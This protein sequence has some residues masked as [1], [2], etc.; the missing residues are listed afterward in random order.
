M[1]TSDADVAPGPA[2]FAASVE[3][4]ADR[5]GVEIVEWPANEQRR[6]HL[7]RAGV[8][9]LLLVDGDAAVPTAI[10]IDEDWVRVPAPLGDIEVRLERLVRSLERLHRERPYV[11]SAHILHYGG[12]SIV[13]SPAQAIVVAALLEQPGRIVS[14][15]GLEREIWPNGTPGPKALDGIVFRL[16]RRLQGVGLVIRSAHARGFALDA[17]DGPDV[18]G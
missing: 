15:H 17:P 1:A 3:S 14:R 4:L 13:L 5:C 16:R 2:E 12:V 8:P 18:V 7:A 10:G 6:R 9:R 11:D